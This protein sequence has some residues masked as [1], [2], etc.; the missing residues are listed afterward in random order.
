MRFFWSGNNSCEAYEVE[1]AVT[2]V[3]NNAVSIKMVSTLGQIIQIEYD[4][5]IYTEANA[6]KKAEHHVYEM[7]TTGCTFFSQD[8]N[9]SLKKS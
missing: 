9:I 3:N 4:M 5:V 1:S 6:S 2:V 8:D 7:A